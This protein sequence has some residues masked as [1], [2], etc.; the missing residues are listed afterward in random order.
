MKVEPIDNLDQLF[1]QAQADLPSQLKARL[2]AIPRLE[3]AQPR[4]D[5]QR[6]LPFLTLLPAACWLVFS[7]GPTLVHIIIAGLQ[8][9]RM[10][11]FEMPLPAWP[12]IPA[13][14]M[15]LPVLPAVSPMMILA[16]STVLVILMSV[17]AWLYF[18]HE[19]ASVA[20]YAQRLT[21]SS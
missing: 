3:A 6:I 7:Y 20:A 5:V 13:L 2:L 16:G 4:W 1:Q 15:T 19:G 12:A 10:P 11:A 9:I 18:E 21:A 8:N 14:G 17:G